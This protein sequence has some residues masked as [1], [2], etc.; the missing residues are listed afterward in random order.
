[1]RRL[2]LLG[3]NFRPKNMDPSEEQRCISVRDE[4]AKNQPPDQIGC[5]IS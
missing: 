2:F 5:E 4:I 3:A 1:M